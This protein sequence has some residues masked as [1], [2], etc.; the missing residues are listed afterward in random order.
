[1]LELSFDILPIAILSIITYA[2][3]LAITAIGLSI[4]LGLL[5]I[6]NVAHGVIFIM[7]SYLGYTLVCS[8]GLNFF[9]ANPLVIIMGIAIAGGIW[10]FIIKPLMGGEL[11]IPLLA[12]YGLAI[13]M[14][15][16][17]KI[18][19]TPYPLPFDP[20][21]VLQGLIRIGSYDY[22]LYRLFVIFAGILILA[23]TYLLLERTNLGIMI[24]AALEDKDMA[25]AMGIDVGRVQLITFLLA[26]ALAS[27]AGLLATPLLTAY[28]ELSWEILLLSFIVTVF[29]GAGYINGTIFA[30]FL[31]STIINVTAIF[32]PPL[33]KATAFI[34]FLITLAFRPRG[35]FG[36]GR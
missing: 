28:Y 16:I 23:F 4:C 1:V 14:I 3:I 12:T 22:P 29:G 19:W 30:A 21:E 9:L 27:L 5:D 8:L 32:A 15:E 26:S 35:I 33:A 31:I 2:L 17:I 18:I 10:K 7:G 6:V 20:P 24:K 36:K 11:T 13:A 34:L 25:K